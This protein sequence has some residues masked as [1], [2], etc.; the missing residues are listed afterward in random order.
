MGE[1]IKE[2]PEYLRP[3][4]K[5]LRNGV[6]TL[7]DAE[8]L[9]LVLRSG[10]GGEGVLQLSRRVIAHAGGKIS[11]IKNLSAEELKK[12]KGIG[13]VK[14]LQLQALSVLSVR[15]N[16]KD[17]S[18]SPVFSTPDMAAEIFGGEMS[19]HDQEVVKI[20][21]LDGRNRLIKQMDISLGTVNQAMV[22]VREI[23]IHALDYKAV[24]MILMHNHP[25]GDPEPSD[26]DIRSTLQ[27]LKAG[28]LT[29]IHLLDHIIIGNQRYVSLR[30]EGYFEAG[31]T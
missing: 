17:D 30:A 27:L 31:L 21:Y 8:L 10:T 28:E 11:G 20:L 6:S 13:K 9:A 24:Y 14:A 22:P 23:L 26:A 3:Y 4:E 5:A 25:A 1:L 15:M 2:I 29:G 16:V 12:L 7:D 19:L 18:E